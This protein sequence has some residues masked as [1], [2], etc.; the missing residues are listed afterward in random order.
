MKRVLSFF[1]LVMTSMIMFAQN[2]PNRLIVHEK[3]GNFKG[4]LTERV[5]SISFAK[6]EGRV[7]ADID[8]KEVVEME[9]GSLA[10]KMAITRTADCVAFRITCLPITFMNYLT[11][12]DK[13]A[14]YLDE[15]VD[16]M[17]WQDFEEGLMTGAEI[18][19][20]A[21]YVLLTV[22]YDKYGIPCGTS[23]AEFTT[24]KATIVGNP[25]VAYTIDDIG[26]DYL[27]MTFTPNDDTSGYSYCLFEAGSAQEQFNMWGPMMGFANLGDMIKAWGVPCYIPDTHTW[28]G[29]TPGTDYEVLIQPWDEN[30]NYG[31][32]IY[33][34]VTT[35]SQGGDG[36]AEVTIEIGQMGGN[37][38]DGYYQVV[39]YTPNDQTKY[40]HD[41]IIAKS[42]YETA[43]WGD[44][45][46]LEFLKTEDD[47]DPWWNQYGVDEACWNVDPS[48]E[49]IAFAIAK[50]GNDEWGPLAR[51]EFSTPATP[52]AAPA[53]KAPAVGKR[54]NGNTIQIQ[55]GVVPANLKVQPKKEMK[56]MQMK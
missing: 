20:D 3:S 1:V 6:I 4:F 24:P 5:D 32:M 2:N 26:T 35:K 33:A 11:T 17:Y 9:D 25:S 54:L 16:G 29:L 50:N 8:F 12:E 14:S 42:I 49:Y 41:M 55:K 34:P 7:A 15:N 13:I 40:F 47:T 30:D 10:I 53:R 39:T 46:V 31:E 52:N 28:T 51:K 22:G 45:G 37:A 43:K 23:K 48:T 27:T 36:V 56:L 38:T 18:T 19:Y 21:T 44:E